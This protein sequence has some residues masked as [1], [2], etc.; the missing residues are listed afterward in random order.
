MSNE[1][2][3]KKILSCQKKREKNG[4]LIYDLFQFLPADNIPRNFRE[5]LPISNDNV[6]VG[7][8]RIHFKKNINDVLKTS[9]DIEKLKKYFRADKQLNGF[10]KSYF[11]YDRNNLLKQT[12][13]NEINKLLNICCLPSFFGEA[14]K[15]KILLIS[16]K[17][18]NSF[19]IE[20]DKLAEEIS[21]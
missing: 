14:T 10:H 11:I 21:F 4:G 7:K 1:L 6:P 5:M 12:F 17:N 20:R 18:T 15:K 2:C 8:E 19:F 13:I 9:Y 3:L 16:S